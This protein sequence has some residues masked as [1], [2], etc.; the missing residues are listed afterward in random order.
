MENLS[1]IAFAVRKAL[2]VQGISLS[3]G[4]TQQ[5]A[6]AALGHQNLASYQASD[7]ENS[8]SEALDIVLD[9]DRLQVRAIEL[10]HDDSSFALALAVA[11]RARF[12]HAQ[13]H[14]DYE[15]W[16]TDVQSHF[17]LAIV[18]EEAVESE[19]AMTNGTFPRTNVELPWWETFDENDDLTYDFDGLVIVDQD[20]ERAFYGDEI[21]VQATLT[22]KR[23]G[24]RLFGR[25]DVEVEYAGLSWLGE[26]SR[27]F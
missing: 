9:M 3:T 2:S 22:V 21:E 14:G 7:D 24:R 23:L 26:P 15:N 11:L 12:P 16:L 19:V 4:H 5:L 6:A 8:L 18:N 1:A 27:K 25:R 13:V 17:E 10:G 20:P